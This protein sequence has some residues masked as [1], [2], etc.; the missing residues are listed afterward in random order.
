MEVD[1]NRNHGDSTGGEGLFS[2][3][4]DPAGTNPG[5]ITSMQ[6]LP[7]SFYD[8][9]AES[10]A[11]ELLGKFLVRRID[12]R[13]R[14]GRIVETE[15]YLGPLDLAA[16]SSHGLTKR[17]EVMHGPPGYAYV[18]LIYGIHHCLN[19]V[20]GPGNHPSAVLLRALEPVANLDSPS[21]S[22]PGRLCRALEIDRRLNGHDLTR[23]ELVVSE[24][25]E[26]TEPFEIIARPRIGVD[27]AG[28]WAGKLLRFYLA[29]NRYISRA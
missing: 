16:H 5:M 25:P 23:G 20:T 4:E 11:R 2:R 10:V 3:W 21:A 14:V 7:R 18:Y 6:I 28:D 29:G 22:G 19:L 17:T 24:P 1:F 26:G 9:D 15:A 8:R 13:K 27:Y 12:R